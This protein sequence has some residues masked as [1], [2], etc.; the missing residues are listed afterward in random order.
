[1]I[2]FIRVNVI[3][4]VAGFIDD[5]DQIEEGIGN[6][7]VRLE[8]DAV[9]AVNF[10]DIKLGGPLKAGREFA[11]STPFAAHFKVAERPCSKGGE[12][13]LP[14]GTRIVDRI[15][16]MPRKIDD[17]RVSLQRFV[18]I[19]NSPV[20]FASTTI[21]CRRDVVVMEGENRLFRVCFASLFDFV[22]K[23]FERVEIVSF[24]SSAVSPNAYFRR[25]SYEFKS[26]NFVGFV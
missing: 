24:M 8:D 14:R 7:V 22:F 17:A 19:L 4:Y 2:A 1:M 5:V 26:L 16:R 13:S 15:M 21:D 6:E 12:T 9:V 11:V 20:V 3:I 25:E 23:P 10:D 18:E